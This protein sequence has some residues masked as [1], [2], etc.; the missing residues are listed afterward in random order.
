MM[1]TRIRAVALVSTLAAACGSAPTDEVTAARAAR[2][3]A[4]ANAG[5]YAPE[6]LRAAEE[7]HAALDAE[8][9]VQDGKWF[10]SYDRAR[11]LAGTARAASERALADAE[12]ARA[13]AET[14]AAATAARARADAERR[15]TLAK[16]AVRVGGPVRAPRKT[17]HVPP[18]YPSIARSSRIGGTVQLELTVTPEGKVGEARVVKSVPL[19]DAAALEAARQWEYT[20]TRVKNVAVPVILN[21]AVE[22]TP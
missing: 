2:D 17:K 16:T 3:R 13:K 7:A 21:V 6:S 8:L 11:S 22:F 14:E 10:K 15:A 12:T 19:L 1:A 4:A 18:V 9:A 5:Q 20:P